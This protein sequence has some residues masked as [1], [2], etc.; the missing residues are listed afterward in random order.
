MA[1]YH[2]TDPAPQ[3]SI[4]CECTSVGPGR[5]RTRIRAHSTKP[6]PP[7]DVRS[8]RPPRG[9]RGVRGSSLRA[10]TSLAVA[11]RRRGADPPFGD[12]GRDHGAGME[13]YY[14]RIVDVAQR[15]V[16]VVLCGVCRGPGGRWALVALAAHPGGLVRH[17]I[18]QPAEGDPHRFGVTAAEILEGSLERLSL[19]LDEDHWIDA[20]LAPTTG[21]PRRA[22]GA[23]ART[24][25]AG[26]VLAPG[27]ARR[28]GTRRGPPG[29]PASAPG[30]RPG[31]AEKNWGPG[32]AGRWWWGQ[33]GAFPDGDLGVAFAGGRCRCW[34][35]IRHPPRR[36]FASA[37]A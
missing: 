8:P 28:R 7:E 2:H 30:G 36:W 34:A 14:W 10:V 32:F 26:A 16:L 22:L 13:G 20:T 12:P 27:D 24:P 21:W 18:A 6:R 5:S 19:R 4:P 37:I 17:A 23:P 29:R 33:A 9:G 35:P 15:S 11:Y 1:V 3:G 31:H 25:R